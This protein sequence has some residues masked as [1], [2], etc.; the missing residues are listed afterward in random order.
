MVDLIV[1]HY[2]ISEG[3]SR[4]QKM[5]APTHGRLTETE[6]LNEKENSQ[7][8][9]GNKKGGKQSEANGVNLNKERERKKRR[10]K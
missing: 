2:V 4:H 1:V 10:K 6:A 8:S 5:D 9:G 7:K 3:F